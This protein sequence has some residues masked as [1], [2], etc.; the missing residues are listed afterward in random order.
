MRDALRGSWYLLVTS[1]IGIAWASFLLSL[2][3]TGVG[4]L[5]VVVGAFVLIATT[6]LIDWVETIEVSRAARF[7]R[8]E[9]AS[10]AP[11]VTGRSR[12]TECTLC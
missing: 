9:V 8:A 12:P 3:A 5:V 1:L 2:L 6:R 4:T 7:L 10:S 11:G